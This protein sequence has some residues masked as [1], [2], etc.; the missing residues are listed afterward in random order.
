MIVLTFR[1]ASARSSITYVDDHLTGISSRSWRGSVPSR[2]W[3]SLN[4]CLRGAEERSCPSIYFQWIN[5]LQNDQ[6]AYLNWYPSRSNKS[7]L[8]SIISCRNWH[9]VFGA[10][11]IIV[12]RFC[13]SLYERLCCEIDNIGEATKHGEWIRIFKQKIENII[14]D[15]TFIS[16]KCLTRLLHY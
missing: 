9:V 5:T 2:V 13:I 16:I 11:R 15:M 7:N 4:S 6:M 14:P 1:C 12:F 8:I 3:I 10:C